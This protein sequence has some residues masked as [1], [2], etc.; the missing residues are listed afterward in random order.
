MPSPFASTDNQ[1]HKILNIVA[2]EIL[3]HLMIGSRRDAANRDTLRTNGVTHILNSTPDCPCHF[4][5]ELEY[6]RISVK[7]RYTERPFSSSLRSL[8]ATGA[9]TD[10]PCPTPRSPS[11]CRFLHPAG[12]LEPRLA[13]AF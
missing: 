1:T 8:L 11:P 9:H 2:S 4:D 7:V 10:Q 3:P 6:L 13:I 12:L 5:S